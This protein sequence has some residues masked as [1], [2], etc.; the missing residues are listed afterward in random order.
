MQLVLLNFISCGFHVRARSSPSLRPPRLALA[1]SHSLPFAHSLSLS[2]ALWWQAWRTDHT[3]SHVHIRAYVIILPRNGTARPPPL[4]P[5]PPPPP[6]PP[7]AASRACE[8][9]QTHIAERPRRRYNA[10]MEHIAR[11]TPA[12]PRHPARHRAPGPRHTTASACASVRGR[13]VAVHMVFAQ[14]R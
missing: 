2:L 7:P 12:A 5:R 14:R 8:N 11:R 6:Y 1:L 10:T 3:N 13:G 4:P 9:R